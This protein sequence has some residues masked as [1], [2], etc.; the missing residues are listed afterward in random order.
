[1]KTIQPI[2]EEQ[3]IDCVSGSYYCSILRI[4]LQSLRR[5]KAIHRLGNLSL[6]QEFHKSMKLARKAGYSHFSVD[7]YKL[8]KKFVTVLNGMS[9]S[10]TWLTYSEL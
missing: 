5:K 6:F 9:E 4:F 3:S 2:F 8:C 10:L 1:M 7:S